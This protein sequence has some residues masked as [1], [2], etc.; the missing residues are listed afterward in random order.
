MLEP[1]GGLIRGVMFHGGPLPACMEPW[2][3]RADGIEIGSV[4][5]A[6]NSPTFNCGVGIAMLDRGR[7]SPGEEVAVE[8]PDGARPATVAAFPLALNSD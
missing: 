3:A 6:A 4:S 8:A 1:P 2:P 7:W 5:S